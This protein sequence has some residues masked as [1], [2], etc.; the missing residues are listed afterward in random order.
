MKSLS[1]LTYTP[2]QSGMPDTLTEIAR[3]FE[4]LWGTAVAQVGG[5]TYLQSDAEGNLVVLEHD[6]EG[7][8]AEDRRRLRVTSEMSLGEMVNRVRP[9]TVAASSS[10]VVVPRAFLATVEGGVYLFATINQAYQ[11]LLIRL[12]SAMADVVASPGEVP[13]GAWRGVRTAVRDMSEEGP[14]R[15]VDGVVVE[16]FL[17]LDEE[18]QGRVVKGLPGVVAGKEGEAVEMIRGLVEGLRRVH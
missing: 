11:D 14:V 12:Q 2:G 1:L 18:G 9:V 4:T 6:K 13:F 5:D 8:S 10:A 16:A 7:F 15:F 17:D 3:H